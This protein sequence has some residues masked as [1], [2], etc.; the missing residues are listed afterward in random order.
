MS[1]QFPRGKSYVSQ[2]DF[3]TLEGTVTALQGTVTTLQGTVTTLENTVETRTH[4]LGMLPRGGIANLSSVYQF[5]N[6]GFTFNA[7]NAVNVWEVP[8]GVEWTF[9][10]IYIGIDGD[11]A[12]GAVDVRYQATGVTTFVETYSLLTVNSANYFDIASPFLVA[13]DG[14]I[15]VEVKHPTVSPGN[16][17]IVVLAYTEEKI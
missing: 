7:T 13:P 14:D 4:S 3:D 17:C 15:R 12:P 11:G 10:G 8:N 16:E 5:V 1:S 2:D 9:K 6:W